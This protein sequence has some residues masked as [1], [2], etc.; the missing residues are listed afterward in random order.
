MSRAGVGYKQSR[1]RAEQSRAE[2]GRKRAGAGQELGSSWAG[3]GQELRM[4]RIGGW[5]EQ[6]RSKAGSGL[7]LEQ[8]RR[9]VCPGTVGL[10]RATV[11]YMALF[12]LPRVAFFGKLESDKIFS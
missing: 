7:K 2:E 8:Q 11:P 9:S 10:L 3:A 12:L 4:C 1:S 6:G 5:K